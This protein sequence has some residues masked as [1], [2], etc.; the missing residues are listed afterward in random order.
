MVISSLL[1]NKPHI[2][3][4][5]NSWLD[6]IANSIGGAID[7]YGDT[8]L[9]RQALGAGGQ[10]GPVQQKSG[11]FL[12]GL[13]GGQ[14]PQAKPQAQAGPNAALSRS[15]LHGDTYRPFIDTVKAGGL[16]NPYALS[17]VAS[18]GKAESGWSTANANRTW[19]DPSESGQPG[20]AGGIMSWRGP[21]Y[22]ALAAT[23]DLSPEGQ[24]KFFIQENPQLIQSLNQAKSVE[25]A[26]GLINKAWAF[27][28]HDR[29][30]GESARRLAMAKSYYANEFGNSPEPNGGAAAI[31]AIAP[32]SGYVDPAV[33]VQ[34]EQPA[35]DNGRFGSSIDPAQAAPTGADIAPQLQQQAAEMQNANAYEAPQQHA[36]APYQVADASGSSM[37]AP[38]VATPIQRGSVDPEVLA[39]MIGNPRMREFG[40]ALWKQNAGQAAGEP[41]QF[42]TLPDGSLVRQNQQTGSVERLGNF[43]KPAEEKTPAS[44]QE[45]Q[46]AKKD[47]FQGTYADWE[48]VKV[49]G[50]S[51]TVN[52]GEGDKFYEKLDQKNAETFSA[53]SDTG[54]QAR[55]K[56]AQID[57]LESLMANAPQGAVGALKQAA[58]EWGIPTEGVSDI[59][60]A[61]ALLEKM[62]PEQRAPG[63]GPMSDADIK[64][65]RASLPRVINQPGGNQLI[66]QTMRGIAQY[67]M[68]MGAIA[69]KVANRELKPD[70]KVYSPAD[71]RRDIAKLENPLSNFRPPSGPTPNEGVKPGDIED[72]YRFKGG[73]PSNPKN[74]EKVQ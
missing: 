18:T 73:S 36:Q 14:Q 32:A 9:A 62:V 46:L 3:Q 56:L 8:K 21:R 64:M 72:G 67:E 59:Q 16:T 61:S 15:G 37:I 24:A 50:T 11:G 26:Q 49:P 7:Q 44:Y 30:G 55:S 57:R 69:D 31:Q 34:Q 70:G 6:G 5:D 10:A 42:A 38:P 28:G 58:G 45:F 39:K 2:P 60:A 52:N 17:A 35:F 22:Q 71:A 43:A 20:T 33:S 29:P 27:A 25:E 74:W 63:S 66:F 54:M 13:M 68:D 51:V 53:L 23:G 4:S 19:S 65:F 40:I 48:K 1:V 12:S 47:G 41:W